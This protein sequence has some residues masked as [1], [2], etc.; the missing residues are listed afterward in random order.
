[1]ADNE[2][3]F[4]FFRTLVGVLSRGAWAIILVSLALAA[5]SVYYSFNHLA[6][7]TSRSDLVASDQ[8]LLRMGEKLS[9]DFGSR[10][11]LV[12]VVENGHPV[13][14]KAFAEA[15]A[16]ELKK[17]PEE[18]PEIFYR[19]RP[20]SFKKWA[21]LYLEPKQIQDIK[22]RLQ[23]HRHLLTELAAKPNLTRFFQGVNQE[24]T[25]SLL[26]ELFVGF[27]KEDQAKQKI[28]D[29]SL[30]TEQKCIEDEKETGKCE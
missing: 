3:S 19:L 17:R 14:A 24:L 12:V 30:L 4:R 15:L 16:A 23:E 13:R 25:N 27:L 11:D 20:E 8:R 9:E 7:R 18:F 1:M 22:N 5:L 10:D 21:L 6:F 2:K 29:L 26:G 28:P